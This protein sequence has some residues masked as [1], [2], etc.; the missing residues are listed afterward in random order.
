MTPSKRRLRLLTRGVMLLAAV[1]C[2]LGVVPWVWAAI[3]VPALSPYVMVCSA[4]ASR[5]VSWVSLLG[6]PV[7]VLSLWRRRWFCRNACPMGLVLEGVGRLRRPRRVRLP[8][9]GPWIVMLTLAAACA[10]YPWLLWADPLAL[11]NA[12]VGACR[13]PMNV[14]GL[15]PAIG[16]ALVI[17]L[18]A[19]WP[20]IWCRRICP[21]GATQ[22]FLALPRR[23]APGP[24]PDPD[25]RPKLTRRTVLAAGLGAL[26]GAFAWR[27]SRDASAAVVRPPGA[28]HDPQFSAMCLRCG[29]CMRVCPTNIIRPDLGAQGV[30]GFLAP[31]VQFE[32]SYCMEDCRR[33]TQ[34]C[35]SRAI[36]PLTLEEKRHTAMGIAKVS[37]PQ[38]LLS[39]DRECSACE[40]QCPYQAIE[41]AFDEESYRT[42]P[43]VD[44]TKCT[45]CGACQ[46]AC[47]AEPKAIA[48]EPRP[49]VGHS[50]ATTS[51]S[52]GW[53]LR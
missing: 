38:C 50:A 36:R 39:D 11:L 18:S 46:V 14:A 12:G 35:P 32:S 31:V 28:L 22:D 52:A 10:G 29:N 41:I 45:G 7:L 37:M 1:T 5:A 15:L 48:V 25:D 44:S 19:L 27:Q 51:R 26:W 42:Q 20:G 53:S 3:V 2:A 6:V 30:A 33:C 40:T 23:L 24:R 34:V 8:A 43:R 49:A 4:I 47:P 17:V 9:L 13:G 21:L 16:F